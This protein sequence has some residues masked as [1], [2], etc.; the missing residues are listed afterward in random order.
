MSE[1]VT[2]ATIIQLF[3]LVT[4]LTGLLIVLQPASVFERL[5][6]YAEHPATQVLAVVVRLMLGALL[7]TTAEQSLYPRVMLGLGWLAIAAAVVLAAIGRS[8]FV[9]LIDWALRL[10][11][12]YGRLSGMF[13]IAFGV[14]LVYAYT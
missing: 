9:R 6:L 8:R 7:I 3:G 4:A 13:A 11:A 2:M 14:F 10:G 1:S 5:R 12:T